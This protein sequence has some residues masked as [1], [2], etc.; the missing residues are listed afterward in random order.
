MGENTVD[1]I[2]SNYVINQSPDKE[3]VIQEVNRN[4]RPGG[5]LHVSGIFLENELPVASSKDLDRLVG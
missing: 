3:R 2:I 4:L 1:V 5:R